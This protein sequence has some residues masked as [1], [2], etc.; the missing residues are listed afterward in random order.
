M[1]VDLVGRCDGLV[2]TAGGSD[3][4]GTVNFFPPAHLGHGRLL[5]LAKTLRQSL[6]SF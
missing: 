1:K 2:A 6:S 3:L 4:V 5:T